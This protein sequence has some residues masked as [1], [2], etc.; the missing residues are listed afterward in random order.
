MNPLFDELSHF[1]PSITAFDLRRSLDK[2]MK[3]DKKQYFKFLSK[4]QKIC[5]NFYGKQNTS[6]IKKLITS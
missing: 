2:V 3:Y 6:Y 4:Q 1:Y 5:K